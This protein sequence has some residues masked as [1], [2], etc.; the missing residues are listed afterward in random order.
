VKKILIADDEEEIRKMLSVLLGSCSYQIIEAENGFEAEALLIKEQPELMIIDVV[1]PGRGGVETII[2]LHYRFPQ[3]K[4]IVISGKVHTESEVFTSLV[5]HFGA[6]RIFSKPFD[7]K[8]L[9]E[10]VKSV[11]GDNP[12]CT[13]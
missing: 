13:D 10:T 6:E 3:L 4:I 5:Q 7:Y 11:M 1:M 2:D 8:Q 12:V 9:V